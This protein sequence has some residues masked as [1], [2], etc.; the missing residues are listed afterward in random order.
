MSSSPNPS[1]GIPAWNLSWGLAKT[2]AMLPN[3]EM[4][5]RWLPR[6]GLYLGDGEHWKL[7]MPVDGDIRWAPIDVRAVTYDGEG[8]LWFAAPQ[9]VGYRIAEN[10]WRL[11]TGA[12]GLPYNDFTCM[13]AGPRGVWF[14][15]TNGAIYFHDGSFSF[16]QGGRWLVDNHVNDIVIDSTGDAWI[17]TPKGV[18]LIQSISR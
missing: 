9:G 15:T 11:F 16:R 12:D 3:Q 4:K 13:A 17:A 1:P 5:S 7:A 18:S 6:S 2:F 8:K 14:G 10:D